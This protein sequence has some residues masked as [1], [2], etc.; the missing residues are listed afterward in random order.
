MTGNTQVCEQT[1]DSV[2]TIVSH[3]VFQISEVGTYKG[4]V[5]IGHNVSFSI[6]ILVETVEMAVAV[7]S[8]KDFLRVS[9]TSKGDIHVDAT[10]LY[11]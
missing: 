5:F 1:I 8:G 4:K 11:I 2:H 7:D 6:G 9:T 10:W 3:P